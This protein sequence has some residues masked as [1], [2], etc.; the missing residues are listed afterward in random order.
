MKLSNTMISFED[1]A[2]AGKMTVAQFIDICKD[3]GTDAVDILEYFWTDKERE[4]REIPGMLKEKGLEIGAFC[5]GNNFIVPAD[6]RSGQ[7]EYVKDGI[8]TAYRLGAKRLRIFGGTTK[9]PEGIKK[10]ERIDII[11]DCIGKVIDYAKENGVTLDI[12]NHGGVPVTSGEILDVLKGVNSPWLKVNFDIGNFLS[13][14][15]QDPMEACEDLYPHVDFVHAKDLVKTESGEKKY[16]SCVTGQG[17]VP[18]KESIEYFNKKGYD[19]YVSLEYEAWET[20]ESKE[21][22][23]LSLDYLRKVIDSV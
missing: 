16:K 20:M 19:G 21:G 15:G 12:E 8:R 4:I 5:V 3:Y 11:I 2:R 1:Y 22:V 23:K 14:G 6:E 17:I 10:E 18:V 7:I 9:I 13:S